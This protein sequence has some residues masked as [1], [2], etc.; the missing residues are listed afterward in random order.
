MLR[1]THFDLPGI[2]GACSSSRSKY[3]GPEG[4]YRIILSDDGDE[5]ARIQVDYKYD[6]R[7]VTGGMTYNEAFRRLCRCAVVPPF[8]IEPFQ[9]GIL[10]GAFRA[11]EEDV[12]KQWT[13]SQNF[14]RE[15]EDV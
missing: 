5:L 9:D 10:W 3:G 1:K 6:P 13:L 11:S 2:D 15:S 4:T 7:L 12:W 14:E 8:H